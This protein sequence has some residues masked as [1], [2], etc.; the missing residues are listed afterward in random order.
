MY[1][2]SSSYNSSYMDSIDPKFLQLLSNLVRKVLRGDGTYYHIYQ[3]YNQLIYPCSSIFKGISFGT[4]PVNLGGGNPA[5]VLE[6]IAPNA[7]KLY[8]KVY[9]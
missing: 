7:L 3:T 4:R 5:W 6:Q 9:E 2:N 1:S 8:Q